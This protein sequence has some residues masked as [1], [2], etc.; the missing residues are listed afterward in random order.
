MD[1]RRFD[2]LTRAV[3]ARLPRRRLLRR[4]AGGLTALLAG[5][6]TAARGQGLPGASAGE[7]GTVELMCRPCL[8]DGD[9][10]E[11]CL[12]GITGGGVVR[13]AAG[14]AQVVL[15]ASR[16][17]D[18]SPRAAGF[19]RWIDPAADGGEIAFESV[20]PIA[21]DDDPEDERAREVRGTM[22]ANGDG[23]HPFLLRLRDAGPDAVGQDTA[24]L[25]V[26][27]RLADAAAPTGFGYEAEGP[28][29]GGDLQLLGTVGPVP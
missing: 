28:L 3:A 6:P 18:G 15:F 23:E 2:A 14:E 4:L 9:D 17:E 25:T 16:I 19:V 20:G 26:G 22:L 29:V 21:Y 11:C 27:D 7:V 8:C 24:S 5:A 12:V 1:A 13:T 10:C